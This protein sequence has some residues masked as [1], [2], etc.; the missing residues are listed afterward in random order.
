MGLSAEKREEPFAFLRLFSLAPADRS[1][2]RLRPVRGTGTLPDAGG[3]GAADT[4]P[5]AHDL[6][7]LEKQRT[8]PQPPT[9]RQRSS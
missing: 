1:R 2:V 4:P 6:A 7:T 3:R 8:R 9:T 5:A